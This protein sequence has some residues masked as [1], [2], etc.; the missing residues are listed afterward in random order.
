MTE[1]KPPQRTA[2]IL[3]FAAEVNRQ[4]A[5]KGMASPRLVLS[6][7]VLAFESLSGPEVVQWLAAARARA[8]DEGGAGAGSNA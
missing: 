7:A 8:I 3:P 6:A 1:K 2:Q 5:K 4:M